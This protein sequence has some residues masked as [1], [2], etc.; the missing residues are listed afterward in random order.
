[1]HKADAPAWPLLAFVL[2]QDHLRAESE[3]GQHPQT[4]G[5]VNP[6]ACH[7]SHSGGRTDQRLP[8]VRVAVRAKSFELKA[9]SSTNMA[10][11]GRALQCA[12]WRTSRCTRL[13]CQ[14]EKV[15]GHGLRL[16]WV[17]GA[18][19]QGRRVC[20]C[21]KKKASGKRRGTGISVL[22][23]IVRHWH[24][25]RLRCAPG[26]WSTD[27]LQFVQQALLRHGP[28]HLNTCLL[29]LGTETV[30]DLIGAILRGFLWCDTHT[31]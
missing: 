9:A 12:L 8:S 10:H 1:M 13:C 28:G 18:V 21:C 30:L 16:R 6:F 25:S 15:T 4:T 17:A 29:Q 19:P 20:G 22:F 27:T 24:L 3:S 11:L 23:R 7:R 31:A 2:R 26:F 5:D 14:Y